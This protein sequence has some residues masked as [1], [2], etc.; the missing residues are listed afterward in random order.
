MDELPSP[1]L[2]DAVW[3]YRKLAAIIVLSAFV[4][5]VAV[6]LLTGDGGVVQARL[7]LEPPDRA[8]VIGA[9]ATSESAFAR[10]INQR[11]LFVTSDRVLAGAAD[12]LGGGEDARSLR[13]V[14]TAETSKG[15]ESIVIEVSASNQQRA[16]AIAAAVIDS[17]RAESES[18]INERVDALLKTLSERRKAIEAALPGSAPGAEKNANAVAAAESLSELDKRATE[19]K[20]AA[21]QLGD[22]VAFVYNAD[23]DGGG[24]LRSVARDGVVGLGLGAVLAAAV[25]WFRADRDRRLAGADELAALVDEPILGEIDRLRGA[26]AG[27]LSWLGRPPTQSYRL[28]AHALRRIRNSGIIVVTGEVGSGCSTT[29]IQLAG[30]FARAGARVLLIDA[31]VGTHGLS[32]SLGLYDNQGRAGAQHGPR[33]PGLTEIATGSM[34]I[35]ETIRVIDLGDGTTLAAVPSGPQAVDAAER[36]SAPRLERALAKARADFDFV[37]IDSAA[38]S[39]A[40]EISTLVRASDSVLLVVRHDTEAKEPRRLREQIRLLGGSI[41]GY[42]YTFAERRR[43]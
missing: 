21:S 15:G 19:I 26:D 36:F 28:L 10:Y 37:L 30:T 14:V 41:A 3:R 4:V 7:A 40:P 9:E 11:A 1:R 17:Y 27:G 42:V 18:E 20:V 24:L 16:G 38:P 2:V 8:G 29:T 31:D 43:F 39:T 22:G 6:A 13:R 25:A 23:P 33:H 35:A 32:S 5:S 12:A 34:V